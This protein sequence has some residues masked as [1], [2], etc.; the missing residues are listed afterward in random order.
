MLL[1][2]SGVALASPSV[3]RVVDLHLTY[4]DAALTY[5]VPDTKTTGTDVVVTIPDDYTI[6]HGQLLKLWKENL[7]AGGWEGG[8]GCLV[9]ELAKSDLGKEDLGEP[10]AYP[11]YDFIGLT[12]KTK[13]TDDSVTPLHG[14]NSAEWIAHHA[15]KALKAHT[16]DDTETDD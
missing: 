15:G 8:L 3:D 2:L 10:P 11:T 9:R 5:S 4:D 16:P 14:K 6:N 1:S 13:G 12:C 7:R